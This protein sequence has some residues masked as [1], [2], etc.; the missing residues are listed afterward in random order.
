MPEHKDHN[1]LTKLCEHLVFI[2]CDLLEQYCQ[3]N[4]VDIIF[5]FSKLFISWAC[6]IL[7][8]VVYLYAICSVL[9]T[10]F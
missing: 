3:R 2:V 5:I 6:C 8:D 1:L 9:Q 10:G 7:F 4:L